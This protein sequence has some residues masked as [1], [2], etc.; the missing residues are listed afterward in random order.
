MPN[1][2][3]APVIE[4][5]DLEPGRILARKYE[6][7]SKLGGGWEGEVYRIRERT[8]GIWCWKDV[9]AGFFRPPPITACCC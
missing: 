6:I 3:R 4:S 5:F 1:K 8:T 9:G 7:V 2:K